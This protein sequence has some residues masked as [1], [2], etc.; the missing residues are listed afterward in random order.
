ML[1][2]SGWLMLCFVGM[3]YLV[4]DYIMEGAPGSK[5]FLLSQYHVLPAGNS[6]VFPV[7]NSRIWVV[8]WTF[9]ITSI[10]ASKQR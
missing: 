10:E 8:V 3:D 7:N 2:L 5:L 1:L 9:K 4:M 6:M